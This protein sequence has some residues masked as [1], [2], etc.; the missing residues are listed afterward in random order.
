M[1]RTKRKSKGLARLA[2]GFVVALAMVTGLVPGVGIRD[3]LA[4]SVTIQNGA[5]FRYDSAANA[6]LDTLYFPSSGGWIDSTDQANPTLQ[7]VNGPD[8]FSLSLQW[9][10][11][12]YGYFL[13]GSS[14]SGNPFS[15]SIGGGK[16][17]TGQEKIKGVKSVLVWDRGADGAEYRL[18]LVIDEGYPLWVGG[19]RVTED[20]ASNVFDDGTVSFVP[21]ANGAPAKLSLNGYV[22]NEVGHSGAECTAPIYWGS[23]D[24]LV[25]ELDGENAV[26][27]AVDPQDVAKESSAIYSDGALQIEGTGSLTAKGGSI[28]ILAKGELSFVGGAVTATG[29]SYGLHSDASVLVGDGIDSL[30]AVGEE[31]AFNNGAIVKNAVVGAGWEDTEGTQ[32]RK[33]IETSDNGQVLNDFKRVEFPAHNHNFSYNAE[34]DTINAECKAEGEC[35]VTEGLGLKI[36]APA[37]L[38]YDGTPKAATIEGGYSEVAFPGEHVICYRCG[39]VEVDANDVVA[40]GTYVAEV[41]FGGATAAV[42]F[43]IGKATPE[44]T[45]TPTASGVTYGQTLGESTLSGG[46]AKVADKVVPGTFSWADPGVVPSVSDGGQ[47][48]Y[49]VTFT[50]A[51]GEAY[52]S[53]QCV[54]K[55]P[56]APREAKLSWKDTSFTY[57][58]KSH[59]P[60][61]SVI[62]LV[63]GDACAV[64]VG[65]AKTNAGSYTATAT[66]LGN[67]NYQLPA[68]ATQKFAIAK[69][70]LTS[71]A[72]VA[73]QAFAGK[74]IAPKPAVKSGSKA[75]RAGTDFSYSYKSNVKA[76]TATVTATGRGNYAGTV[77][78]TFRI[79][80]ATTSGR[81]HLQGSGWQATRSDP[82]FYGTTGQSLRME[83]LSLSLPK[84]F[85]VKG[86][87]QY[88]SHLQGRGWEPKW[89]S[90]GATS[91]TVGQSRRIEAIQ[92]RLTGEVAKKYDVWY[93]VH[94]QRYGWMGW[95][96][97]GAKAGTAGMSRR[98]E[99]VQV[100]LVPKGGKAPA[101]TYRGQTQAF[102]KAFVA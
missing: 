78:T 34:G 94:S 2:L 3:A 68:A 18:E 87:I 63:A 75:L 29:S 42:E 12:N 95:A 31:G 98:A 54:A 89:A 19:I 86:S 100:V 92:I 36:L 59:K 11:P 15:A 91:G 46:E 96:K 56:V 21:A 71:I 27:A 67:A 79:V 4:S 24:P 70:K 64:T 23:G 84:G 8:T 50:P 1:T 76:G 102:A 35:D 99:A 22:C 61:A 9:N 65:G 33:A 32:G 37:N 10:G 55:L 48:E 58:G 60:A 20:N 51:D 83:A 25:I 49:A 101:A 7:R 5:I 69:A 28:G 52:E 81:A 93:R 85:P 77:K 41:S 30:V 66:K 47:T 88:R 6:F 45:S 17:L 90:D 72:K 14:G 82:A 53:A 39:G 57:D 16:G 62:N 73:D 26:T 74:A 44:V 43:V 13:V 80:A 40:P 38:T 97:N